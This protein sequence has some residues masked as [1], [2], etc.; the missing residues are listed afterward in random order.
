[1]EYSAQ[2]LMFYATML[3]KIGLIKYSL[4]RKK[5]F[6]TLR[7]VKILFLSFSKSNFSKHWIQYHGTINHTR[8][9]R[10]LL[11]HFMIGYNRNQMITVTHIF[12]TAI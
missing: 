5:N 6:F 9:K 1:M 10:Y 3:F 11:P 2:F 4:E 7:I 12:E 8:K